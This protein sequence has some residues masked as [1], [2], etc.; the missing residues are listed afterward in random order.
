ML[1]MHPYGSRVLQRL[2]DK[3]SWRKA[4]LLVNEIKK[5]IIILSKN[6]YGNYIIQ[7]II[8]HYSMERREIVLKLIGHVAKL[9][10]EKFAS[11][12]IEMIFRRSSQAHLRE[13][14]EELLYDPAKNGTFPT[15]A[16]LLNNQFGTYVIQTLLESSCG[17]FRRRLIRSLSSCGRSNKNYGGKNLNVKVGRMLWRQSKNIRK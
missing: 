14:A 13:L 1:S 17:A 5:H 12:V 9:S 11:N 3:V 10:K 16:H 15:L 7:C 8:K 4:R 6:Q 2:L